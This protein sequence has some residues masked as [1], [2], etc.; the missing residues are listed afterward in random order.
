MSPP[1][2]W[3]TP[4]KTI[5]P[6]QE[7]NTNSAPSISPERVTVEGSEQIIDGKKFHIEKRSFKSSGID[8]ISTVLVDESGKV[9]RLLYTEDAK[10][11]S[12]HRDFVPGS[13]H[14]SGTKTA[15]I[16]KRKFVGY[17]LDIVNVVEVDSEGNIIKI[18]KTENSNGK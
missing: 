8:E 5:L 7:K 6:I 13:E 2:A 10:T 17:G 4:E 9:V 18:L 14:L 12:G 15:H 3:G 11:G 16:E 1:I